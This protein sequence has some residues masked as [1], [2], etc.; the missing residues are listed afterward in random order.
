MIISSLM[1][2]ACGSDTPQEFT[3][4]PVEGVMLSKWAETIDPENVLPEYPRPQ[5][6]RNEWLNLNG[7]WDFTLV[8]KEVHQIDSYDHKILVP[9]PIE[10]ALSGLKMT[11][12][13]DDKVWYRRSFTIPDHWSGKRMLLNFGAVDWEATVFLNGK[14]IGE[15]R[16]GFPQS[17]DWG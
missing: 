9:F 12:T 14:K 1:L 15:H 5:M 4:K 11:V 10:S 6:V 13:K 16:G 2:F 7:L 8:S 3:W 17:K